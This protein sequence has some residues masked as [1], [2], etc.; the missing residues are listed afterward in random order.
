M[1]P[2]R[3]P[4]ATQGVDHEGQL[5]WTECAD[6]GAAI[7]GGA[8]IAPPNELCWQDNNEWEMRSRRDS[9]ESV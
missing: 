8:G 2:E 1:Q 7:G 3:R 4:P 6:P 9:G 5:P